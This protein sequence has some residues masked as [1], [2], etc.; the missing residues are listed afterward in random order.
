MGNGESEAMQ[1]AAKDPTTT[2]DTGQWMDE[3]TEG[4]EWQYLQYT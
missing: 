1:Q 2:Q 3:G 4:R